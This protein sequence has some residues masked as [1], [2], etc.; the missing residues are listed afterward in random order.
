[1]RTLAFSD[2]NITTTY[3]KNDKLVKFTERNNLSNHHANVHPPSNSRG[4]MGLQMPEWGNITSQCTL[5]S[6]VN[7]SYK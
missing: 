4:F 5:L 1:M 7:K 3:V 6:I 2:Q